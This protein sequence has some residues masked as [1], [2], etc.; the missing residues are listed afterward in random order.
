MGQLRPGRLREIER[1]PA[2]ERFA[3][4]LRG[5]LAQAEVHLL[6]GEALDLAVVVEQA[7]RLG[8]V[9]AAIRLPGLRRGRAA[10]TRGCH[11]FA[12]P[13]TTCEPGPWMTRNQ[14]T[15]VSA[16]TAAVAPKIR[17]ITPERWSWPAAPRT[18][19]PARSRGG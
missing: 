10:R 5:L 1:L 8:L 16:H 13:G 4:A 17:P 6:L 14:T 9:L 15:N 7:H 3:P 11:D 19:I 2:R 18:R 12:R